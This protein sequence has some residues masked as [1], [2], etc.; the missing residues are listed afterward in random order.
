MRNGSDQTCRTLPDD[1]HGADASWLRLY[2]RGIGTVP[3]ALAP[4]P[5]CDAGG[6]LGTKPRGTDSP[7]PG[8]LGADLRQARPAGEHPVRPA[9]G[10]DHSGTGQAAGPCSAFSRGYGP[11]YSG[12]G[13]WSDSR[14]GVRI[15]RSG[16]SCGGLHRPGTSWRAPRRPGC[17]H[18]NSAARSD[19]NHDPGPGNSP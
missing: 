1:R 8:G 6:A 19:A 14:R 4:P 7:R 9:P 11:A 2:G 17:G 5:A 15:L 12:A 13:A 10:A 18:Q 16:P 3:G